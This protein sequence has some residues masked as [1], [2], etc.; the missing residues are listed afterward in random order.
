MISAGYRE[1]NVS[2]HNDI[3]GFDV[4]QMSLVILQGPQ[5]LQVRAGLSQLDCLASL[6]AGACHDYRHDGFT[7]LWHKNKDTDRYKAFGADGTQEKFHFAESWKV[8]TEREDCN[9][10]SHLSYAEQTRFK[11][12]MQGCIHATDMG[13]HVADLAAMK[14]MLASLQVTSEHQPIINTSLPE[15]ELLLQQ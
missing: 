12:R 4:C 1:F 9:F 15:N 10:I 2:Y 6:I 14:E 3:H 13:R 7:N 11:L 8:L 5:G